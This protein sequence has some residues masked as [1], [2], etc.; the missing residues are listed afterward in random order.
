MQQEMAAK[1]LS[2]FSTNIPSSSQQSFFPFKE[3][4]WGDIF[5]FLADTEQFRKAGSHEGFL[6]SI[7]IIHIV[8]KLSEIR[9]Q[10]GW[11]Q[12]ANASSESGL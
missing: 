7:S 4:F 3:T 9:T 12:S 2:A 10:V 6:G 11:V 5:S 8:H 1:L